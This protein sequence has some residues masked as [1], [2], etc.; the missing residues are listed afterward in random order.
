MDRT[1]DTLKKRL[2]NLNHQRRIKLRLKKTEYRGFS[3]YLDL[4]DGQKRYYQFLNLYAQANR[5]SLKR[6]LQILRK[7]H[8]IR[9]GKEANLHNGEK[10]TAILT[11]SK[12]NIDF[13]D[14]FADLAAE[15]VH[16]NWHSTLKHLQNFTTGKICLKNIDEKYC[17]NFKKYLLQRVNLNTASA[18]FKKFKFVLN[19]AV[20]Q[21]YIENNP[22]RNIHIRPSRKPREFLTFEELKTIIAV[23]IPDQEIKNAFIFACFTGLK[24]SEIKNLKFNQIDHNFLILYDGETKDSR[25]LK[26]HQKAVEIIQEQKE[27]RLKNPAEEI[28][29]LPADT[30]FV[31]H[32]IKTWMQKAGIDKHITFQCARHTF[33]TMCLSYGV[34]LY[35]LSKILG[36]RDIKSTEIYLRLIETKPDQPADKLPKYDRLFRK[37]VR[38]DSQQMELDLEDS[39]IKS[40]TS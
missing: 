26:L 20:R 24:I 34:D 18:Y 8:H 38:T 2:I 23:P 27:M 29:L 11:L 17:H 33:A 3:L 4:W 28:F 25:G 22:A 5:G 36:H 1:L 32:S 39:V 40:K 31:N 16:R 15:K 13:I 35:T 12:S 21:K 30:I 19:A 14:F 6:D 10:G 37:F 9:E 7:A